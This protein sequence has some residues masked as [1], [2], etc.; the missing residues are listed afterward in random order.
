M[1][2]AGQSAATVHANGLQ[3]GQST[4]TAQ[5]DAMQAQTQVTVVTALP[6]AAVPTSPW[7]LIAALVALGWFWRESIA[8]WFPSSCMIP[9]D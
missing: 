7:L 6:V 8:R 2:L 4:L 5:L 3:S 9:W 1:I